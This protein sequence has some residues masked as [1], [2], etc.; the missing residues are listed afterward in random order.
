MVSQKSKMAT[1]KI[2]VSDTIK[3]IDVFGIFKKKQK[4]EYKFPVIFNAF[5]LILSILFKGV[6]N[7]SRPPTNLNILN[8][9]KTTL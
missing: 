4:T 9:T 2:S 3:T 1:L 7:Y 6:K 5:N 8:F